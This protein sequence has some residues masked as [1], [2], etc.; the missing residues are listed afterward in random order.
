MRR[1]IATASRALVGVAPDAGDPKR[2]N[3]E[4]G[5]QRRSAEFLSGVV[6]YGSP[7]VRLLS[8]VPEKPKPCKKKSGYIVDPSVK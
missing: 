7:E 4:E 5:C 8:R 1:K 6:W 3:P 2:K